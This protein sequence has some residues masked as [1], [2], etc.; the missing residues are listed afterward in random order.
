METW[1]MDMVD[2]IQPGYLEFTEDGMGEFAFCAVKGWM[3]VRVS[4]RTPMLEFSWQGVC[5]GD[6]LNGRGRIEFPTPDY[7]E[8]QIFIHCG[9]ESWFKIERES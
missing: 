9:D 6:E 4:H 7:G 8:G 5:E 3:D 2:M 1:D